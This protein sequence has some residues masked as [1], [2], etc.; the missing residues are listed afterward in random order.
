MYKRINN[1]GITLIALVIT[2][3]ILLVLAGITISTLA[4]ENGLI[5]RVQQTK[6]AQIE[7][8]MKEQLALALQDLQIEKLG[9]A[10]LDDVTQEWIDSKI[11]NYDCTIKEDASISGKRVIMEKN[12]VICKFLIDENLNSTVIEESE[13]GAQLEYET[14]SRDGENVNILITITDTE[15]GLQQVEFPD[16]T[17]LYCNGEEQVAKDYE[18]QLGVE[19]IVKITSKDGQVKE[20]TILINDYYHKI[21]KNLGEGISID[22]TAIK[23]AYNKPYQAT[24]TAG[25]EYIINAITVT[26]GGEAVTVDT[27]T[28]VINIEK[29]TGDI[30]ITAT[31]KKLKIVTTTPIVNT[32]SSATSSLGANTQTIGTTVY[33]NFS[34]TLEG[35]DCTI[36]P[37]VPYE[38]TSNGNYKFTVTGIY[39]DKTITKEV[40]VTVNQYEIVGGFVSY[41]AGEWTQEEIEALQ[42]S[43]LY[44]LNKSYSRNTK[45]KLNDDS[46]L[47]FTFGGFT[48]K[49]DTENENTEGIITNRNKSATNASG[50]PY[51]DGWKI[52]ESKQENGKIYITKIIHAGSPENFVFFGYN[53]ND[54]RRAVYLLSNGEESTAYST[55]SD[56]TTTINPRNWDIYK[57]K[58]LDANGYIKKVYALTYK[59]ASEIPS[60]LRITGANYWLAEPK[61]KK[62]LRA[63]R[64]NG[65][66]EFDGGSIYN[67]GNCGCYGIRPVVELNEGVYIASGDGTEEAPYVLAKE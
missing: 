39:R 48:Y 10:T 7:S 16:G 42:S 33:I 22:N 19:Y 12:G 18:V 53:D 29:V 30:E 11:Q 66:I 56:R 5:A 59:E 51:Y 17:I 64:Y 13:S 6:Q 1:K 36:E 54:A 25:D 52:L 35:I 14:I 32:D 49:G 9:D 57:D 61:T 58:T 15:N 40:E 63:T 31:A 28:G 21:T 55:L 27:T 43:K 23:A 26:M 41:D 46:G 60:E 65:N 2:I 34:A 3:V 4:G 44:D 24:I 67:N 38:V 50:T 37:T 20:E 45:Y 47:I 62:M 8:D